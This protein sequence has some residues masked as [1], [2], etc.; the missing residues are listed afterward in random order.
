MIESPLAT[1]TLFTIGP[2][3]VT[4]PAIVTW[5]L[6]A[7]L[8][9]AGW[10]ATH[11]LALRPSRYQAVLELIV[12]AIEDQIQNTTRIAP[13]PYVPLIGTLFLFILAAN[14]SS[15]VP[16]IEP[17]AE[18]HAV[19][20]VTATPLS[21]AEI[22]QVRA[23]LREALGS[24]PRFEVRSVPALVAGIELHGPSVIVRNRV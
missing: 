6:M 18:D 14:W 22:D 8:T 24:Q 7:A 17:P 21:K 1:R 3:P 13:K 2:V 15:M 16:G 20:V 9:I 23:A 12:G 11:S 10:L 4:E 19:E 5:G